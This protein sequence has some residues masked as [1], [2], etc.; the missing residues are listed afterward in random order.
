M[1]EKGWS[2]CLRCFDEEGRFEYLVILMVAIHLHT[3][4]PSR[5]R[6]LILELHGLSSPVDCMSRAS[7]LMLSMSPSA[8]DKESHPA[9]HRV[10]SQQPRSTS[11]MI[12][13]VSNDSETRHRRDPG[14][15]SLS[16]I[17]DGPHDPRRAR[18]DVATQ[19]AVG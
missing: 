3:N 9:S 1:L 2:L 16:R 15:P 12:L 7:L 18:C 17:D 5:R 13:S 19:V 11:E 8:S 4:L 14:T 6:H 10:A